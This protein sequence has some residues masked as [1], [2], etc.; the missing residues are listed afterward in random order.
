M[1]DR[2][3][4]ACKS[5]WKWVQYPH[6]N[7]RHTHSRLPRSILAGNT[8]SYAAPLMVDNL[9]GLLLQRAVVLLY[10]RTCMPLV[11]LKLILSWIWLSIHWLFFPSPPA[12][13]M[14]PPKI[15]K[16][17]GFTVRVR[18]VGQKYGPTCHQRD[19]ADVT[20]FVTLVRLLSLGQHIGV[21]ALAGYKR[22]KS[23]LTAGPIV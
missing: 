5:R 4:C 7:I 12:R 22:R 1:C 18:S 16:T 17:M 2:Q 9:T 10:S 20:E 11:R 23:A 19:R 14:P 6:K 3:V 15:H 21:L 8:S 13:P